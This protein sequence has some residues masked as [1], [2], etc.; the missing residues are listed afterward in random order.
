MQQDSLWSIAYTADE[1]RYWTVDFSPAGALEVFLKA[2][3][4]VPTGAWLSAQVSEAELAQ[5]HK[6][7]KSLSFPFRTKISI[8]VFSP[9][10]EAATNQHSTTTALS[11]AT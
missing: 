6:L 2:N 4:R 3:A 9:P 8:T 1:P 5:S 10:Q 11:T 7:S